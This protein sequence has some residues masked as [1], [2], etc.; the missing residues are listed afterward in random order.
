MIAP[1]CYYDFYD[2]LCSFVEA[3][4]ITKKKMR[5]MLLEVGLSEVPNVAFEEVWTQGDY[6]LHFKKPISQLKGCCGEGCCNH[7]ENIST[8]EVENGKRVFRNYIGC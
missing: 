7:K 3:G 5:E 8:I 1:I 6:L 4:V 2:A